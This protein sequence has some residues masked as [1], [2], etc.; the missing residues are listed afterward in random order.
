MIR[1]PLQQAANRR[2]IGIIAFLV[3]LLM[4]VPLVMR[5]TVSPTPDLNRTARELLPAEASRTE[6]VVLYS[7]DTPWREA[8]AEDLPRY[9]EV[10]NRAYGV[11]PPAGRGFAPVEGALLDSEQDYRQMWTQIFG[12]DNLLP[13]QFGI[14]REK[15]FLYFVGV[16]GGDGVRAVTKRGLADVTHHFGRAVMEQ[17]LGERY[18]YMPGW[19]LAIGGEMGAVIVY[20]EVVE[21]AWRFLLTGVD[22]NLMPADRAAEAIGTPDEFQEEVEKWPMAQRARSL[23]TIIAAESVAGGRGSDWIGLVS[24]GNDVETTVRGVWGRSWDELF[25][26]LKQDAARRA[27]AMRSE[28]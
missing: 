18:R 23:A 1:D 15:F 21:E 8:V 19:Y 9:E 3:I 17:Y 12:R 4:L 27:T 20:P 7:G 22:G 26:Q 6:R 11:R 24:L 16:P 28:Q 5:L 2:T 25:V 14:G 13:G 10:M